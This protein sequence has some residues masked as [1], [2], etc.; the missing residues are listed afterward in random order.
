MAPPTVAANLH[1]IAE[2]IKDVRIAMMITHRTDPSGS[3]H[4]IQQLRARP[5]YTQ[6]VDPAGFSG[7]LWFFTDQSTEKV[8]EIE[9]HPQIMLLY[10]NPDKN[11]FIVA[12]GEARC[13]HNEAKARELWNIHA[14]GWWPEG[15]QSDTLRLIRVQLHHA[16]Y[17]QGPSN[18]SYMLSLLKAVAKG[19]R[20]ELD[21]EHG[22]VEDTSTAPER[23]MQ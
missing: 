7:E 5:M 23:S 19:E 3:P 18:T 12:H 11:T 15:P 17:W 2:L 20:V 8:G 21:A 9:S 14:K 16:E 13:E 4:D 22:V 10:A 1:T 6:K